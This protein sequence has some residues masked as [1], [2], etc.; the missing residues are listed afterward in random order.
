M[1][2]L[3]L[4]SQLSLDLKAIALDFPQKRNSRHLEL[5]LEYSLDRLRDVQWV[6]CQTLVLHQRSLLL[7]YEH[8]VKL[9]R[10]TNQQR[11]TW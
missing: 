7:Q 3:W 1:F 9:N 11:L 10:G 8:H 2:Q 4:L 5:I 6:K